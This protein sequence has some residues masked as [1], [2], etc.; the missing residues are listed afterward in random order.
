MEV[1][2]SDSQ[3]GVFPFHGLLLLL[4]ILSLPFFAASIAEE[5]SLLKYVTESPQSEKV[6]MWAFCQLVGVTRTNQALQISWGML[7]PQTWQEAWGLL[8][9]RVFA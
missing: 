1:R 5:M 4:A 2:S 3:S 7:S 9:S 8:F 6:A